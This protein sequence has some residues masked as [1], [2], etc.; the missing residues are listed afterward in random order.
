MHV[1]KNTAAVIVVLILLAAGAAVWWQTGQQ[2]TA[3]QPQPTPTTSTVA[4]ETSPSLGA[5]MLKV[6]NPENALWGTALGPEGLFFVW[7]TTAAQETENNTYVGYTVNL[8]TGKV[9]ESIRRDG[10][11]GV[12]FARTA[13]PNG[14]FALQ[15]KEC[16]EGCGQINDYLDLN[17]TLRYTTQWFLTWGSSAAVKIGKESHEISLDPENGCTGDVQGKTASVK[18]FSVDGHLV[19]FAHPRTV[20]CDFGEMGGNTYKPFA[21]V[22]VEGAQSGLAVKVLDSTYLLGVSVPLE[23]FDAAKATII[24]PKN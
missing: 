7:T 18:G 5:A 20:S 12:E 4:S 9:V 23:P 14:M 16:W 15:W 21:M 1:S 11:G 3:T 10:L 17:G 24:E 2:P 19:A 6:P 13:A 8:K 22:V